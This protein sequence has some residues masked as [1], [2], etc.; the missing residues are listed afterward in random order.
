MAWKRKSSTSS[1]AKTK[2]KAGKPRPKRISQGCPWR[3][4]GR[5]GHPNTKRIGE[6]SEAAFIARAGMFN[7]PVAKLWGEADSTD[8]LVGFRSKYWRVQVKCST[9]CIR[10]QYFVNAGGDSHLYT[11][12]DIDFIAAHIVPEN[13]WYIVP[14]ESFQGK[15]TLHFSPRRGKAKY[16][17]YREAWCLLACPEKARGGE[18][19]PVIC[20]CKD[21]PVRC[22]ACPGR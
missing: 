16:E 15:S 12:D 17:K 1:K 14:I 22:A 2:S 20:R 18:D 8:T 11:K 3:P 10:G 7:F 13:I 9:C 5:I 21:L 19:R 4:T 6:A